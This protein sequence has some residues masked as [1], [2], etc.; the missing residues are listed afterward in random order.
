MP[1]IETDS[2]ALLSAEKLHSEHPTTFAIP[3]RQAR[4][5]LRRGDA[6]KLLFDIETKEN[7]EV[8]DRGVDRMWV[9]VT[10]CADGRYEGVLDNDPGAADGLTLQRG[11]LISFLPE[12]VADIDRPPDEYLRERFGT[13]FGTEGAA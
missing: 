8:V 10:R 5:A 1:S 6:A 3:S 4:E 12:D 11:A 13:A 9:V 2:W 7:G